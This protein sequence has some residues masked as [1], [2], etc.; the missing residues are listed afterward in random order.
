[1]SPA[2]NPT[3]PKNGGAGTSP[4]RSWVAFLTSVLRSKAERI[5]SFDYFAVLTSE[6]VKRFQERT[7]VVVII[8]SADSEPKNAQ[9]KLLK[10]LIDRD[11]DPTLCGLIISPF[12]VEAD[13]EKL[14]LTFMAKHNR[15]VLTVDQAFTVKDTTQLAAVPRGIVPDNHQGGEKAGEALAA[16]YHHLQHQPVRPLFQVVM[17]TGASPVRRIGFEAG[18]RRALPDVELRLEQTDAL[19]FSRSAGNRWAREFQGWTDPDLVGVFAC[20]DELA[21]GVREGLEDLARERPEIAL[22]RFA[23]VGFDGIRDARRLIKTQSERW[24]VNTVNVAIDELAQVL[25]E[26]YDAMDHGGSSA[27]QSKPLSVDLAVPLPEQRFPADLLSNRRRLVRVPCSIAVLTFKEEEYQALRKRM[28][29]PHPHPTR[30]H[31]LVGQIDG[32]RVALVRTSFQGNIEAQGM[33]LHLIDEVSPTWVVVLG[34][35]GAMPDSGLSLGDVVLGDRVMNFDIHKYEAGTSL[36]DD[37]GGRMDRDVLNLG[38]ELEHAADQ[39][40][41]WD[42]ELNPEPSLAVEE[43]DIRTDDP[44]LRR[45]IAENI[46]KRRDRPRR[47]G[48]ATIMSDGGLMKD[49]DLAWKRRP[50]TRGFWH[51]VDMESGGVYRA[52]KERDGVSAVV[53][54]AVSDVVGF[55]K[56]PQWTNYA[57]DVAAEFFAKVVVKRLAR[58][59]GHVRR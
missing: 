45:M 3:R 14:A 40:A 25:K 20:N 9:M 56:T 2:G 4:P 17:G 39:I 12:S 27:H 15:P 43:E 8:P 24:L 16:Y 52:V 36:P 57:C 13:V 19:E 1:V 51:V 53:V 32:T 59:R 50:Q 29:G 41:G 10:E 42:K 38:Q 33:A 18:L 31:I 35:G 47:F 49:I 7:D 46:S 58:T 5:D 34:I 48:I 28:K 55:A 54:R 6:V 37:L 11:I 44:N 22:T 26:T 23:L 21:L 30:G